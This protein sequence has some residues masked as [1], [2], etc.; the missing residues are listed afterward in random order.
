MVADS[1]GIT[2]NV[3][4][5][6]SEQQIYMDTVIDLSWLGATNR[7]GERD[8]LIQTMMKRQKVLEV[9]PRSPLIQGLLH[10][11]EQIVDEDEGNDRDIQE[12]RE[13]AS[14][15]IDGALVRSGF[16]VA[17]SNK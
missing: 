11:I 16:D 3:Q 13:V 2:A 5:L 12:L 17:D 9:N 15:L 1:T 6:M 4:K 14:I 7:G 10:R 8:E